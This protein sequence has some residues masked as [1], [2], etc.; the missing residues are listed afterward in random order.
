MAAFIPNIFYVTEK[1]WNFYPFT[2]TGL[3][4]GL[5]CV[6]FSSKAVFHINWMLTS[7]SLMQVMK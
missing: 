4:S 6:T 3:F 7:F 5:E 2:I 1:A